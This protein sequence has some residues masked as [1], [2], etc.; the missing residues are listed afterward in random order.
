MWVPSRRP[1][2][3]AQVAQAAPLPVRAGGPQ[4]R[5]RRPHPQPSIVLPGP[6]LHRVRPE[7]AWTSA[8]WPVPGR[9]Q[10]G[11]LG[12]CGRNS[13][14]RCH[15]RAVGCAVASGLIGSRAVFCRSR[16]RSHG[17]LTGRNRRRFRTQLPGDAD[18]EHHRGGD[19]EHGRPTRACALR[20]RRLRRGHCIGRRSIHGGAG[21]GQNG[22]VQC[23]RRCLFGATAEQP[24]Q[25]A[26]FRRQWFVS[27]HAFNP[28]RSL[29]I[30]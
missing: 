21:R 12:C 25:L 24:G 7:R 5:H 13:R 8:R 17:R 14:I 2:P 18:G 20:A 23:G 10:R 30:A 9:R 16:C 29:S 22:G 28:A 19:A 1:V 6:T 4:R 26:F 27:V 15:H 11:R 3:V